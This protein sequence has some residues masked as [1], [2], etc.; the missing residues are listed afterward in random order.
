MKTSLLKRFP[1]SQSVLQVYAVIAVM[2]SGWTIIVFLRKLPSWLLT[3]NTGEIFTVFS[4]AIVVNLIESL[5]VLSLL[6]A[7]CV[8]LPPRLFRD[9]FA[10]RG[11]I[12]SLGL[13]GSLITVLLLLKKFGIGGT[14]RLLMGFLAILL[15][16]AVL[17]A[18][19]AKV[20]FIQTAALWI[21]DRLVVF[22]FVL[23]PLSAIL[24][25]YVIIRNI[26]T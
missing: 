21:S 16:T 6:L 4:Y 26:I 3:L 23:M 19:S 12:A 14:D 17:L 5:I 2:F 9:Q 7:I 10:V 1:E 25:I 11:T 13:I 8:L 18:F 24:L 15:L 22:L 20:R